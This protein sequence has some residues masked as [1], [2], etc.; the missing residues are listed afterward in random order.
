MELFTAFIRRR[1]SKKPGHLGERLKGLKADTISSIVASVRLF[2]ERM[3]R[4]ELFGPHAGALLP[5][6]NKRM[7]QED[8]PRGERKLSRGL[9]AHMLRELARLGYDRSTR[10]GMLDWAAALLAHN[11]CLRGGELGTTDKADF[12][13]ARGITWSSFNW[14]EPCPESDWHMWRSSWTSWTATARRSPSRMA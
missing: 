10:R 3:Q 7:R 11:L 14:K 1:G 4:C 8:G 13:P 5:L 12:D 9:R 2:A 6:M